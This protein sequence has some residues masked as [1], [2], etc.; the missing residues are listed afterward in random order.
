[1]HVLVRP[2]TSFEINDGTLSISEILD[3]HLSSSLYIALANQQIIYGGLWPLNRIVLPMAL[4]NDML[5][6]LWNSL[7]VCPSEVHLGERVHEV[8]IVV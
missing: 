1:M 4:E 3:G 7:H 6:P 2:A 5:K 8:F